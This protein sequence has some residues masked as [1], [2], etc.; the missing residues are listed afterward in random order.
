MVSNGYIE[1][2]HW[3][4][5]NIAMSM[6]PSLVLMSVVSWF[7]L[8]CCSRQ[9]T[10]LS[11][12]LLDNDFEEQNYERRFFHGTSRHNAK[13]IEKHGFVASTGGMLGPGVYMSTDYCK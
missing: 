9:K 10:A 7:L 8:L 11:K 6:V 12:P 4:G 3:L 2:R 13:L 1:H 5:G